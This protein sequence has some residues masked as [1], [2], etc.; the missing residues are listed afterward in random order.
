MGVGQ[1]IVGKEVRAKTLESL[2][3]GRLKVKEKKG[4][5]AI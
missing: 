4:E 5:R 1:K 2:H 3:A